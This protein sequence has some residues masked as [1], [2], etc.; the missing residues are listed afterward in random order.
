MSKHRIIV[1][2][3]LNHQHVLGFSS[4][5]KK[6]LNYEMI[7]INNNPNYLIERNKLSKT[8]FSEIY[9]ARRCKNPFLDN[10]NKSLSTI[11]YFFV[12][13]K[14]VDFVLFHYLSKFIYPLALISKWRGM[15]TCIFVYGSDFKRADNSY[16]AYINK[17][18][19]IVDTIVCDSSDMLEE[20]RLS[21]PLHSTK[22]HCC[23]FGSPIVDELLQESKTKQEVKKELNLCAKDK[24]VIMCGYNGCQEQQH[25]RIINHLKIMNKRI[26]IILPMTYS[27][28][29]LY[30]QDVIGCCRKNG[31]SFTI[32]NHFLENEEWKKYLIGT[33]VFIHMQL[34]DAF[35]A[36]LSEQLLLGNVVIN[37]EWLKYPD[38]EKAGV[39]YVSANFDNLQMKVE[40]V[41]ANFNEYSMHSKKNKNI[42]ERFK[43]LE[44]T[45]K[46]YWGP[47]F[48]SI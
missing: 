33:D 31:I 47:Y 44:Y 23:F 21:F 42:I 37:A 10:F 36:C 22:M 28:D 2:G 24:V 40:D 16:K 14:K 13:N 41:I 34:T 9:N 6:Y 17:T 20:L 5:L 29:D 19:K 26:H 48:E 38:L 39:Y 18:F 4:A 3:L 15:K 30:M 46:N 27:A 7:G 43:G 1:F 11:Y 35:S 32:L 8:V 45:V 25:I 12:V